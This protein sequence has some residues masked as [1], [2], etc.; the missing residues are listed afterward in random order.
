[1]LYQAGFMSISKIRLFFYLLTTVSMFSVVFSDTTAITTA[2]CSIVQAVRNIVGVLALCLFMLGG[3]MYAVSHFLPTN[4]EF[5][6]SLS[7]WSSAMIVGGIIGLVIVLIAQPL[8]QMITGI[9][10]AVGGGTTVT[11]ITC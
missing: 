8:V 3:V 7:A 1:M 5:K 11:T 4:M 2:L 9:G 6:K 10:T